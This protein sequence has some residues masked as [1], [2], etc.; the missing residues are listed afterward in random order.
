M[1]FLQRSVA[2]VSAGAACILT[3][4]GCASVQEMVPIVGERYRVRNEGYSLLY[5][6]TSK[7]R[8]VDKILK[9]KHASPNVAAVIKEI[10]QTFRQATEQLDQIVKTDAGLRFNSTHLPT[11]EVKT[12]ASIEGTTAKT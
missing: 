9:L 6:L 11:L 5:E 12:R 4:A 1:I 8:D 3:F 2:I 7:Q 10:A